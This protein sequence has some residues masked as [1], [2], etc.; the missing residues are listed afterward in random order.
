HG[1]GGHRQVGGPGP[2]RLG[3]RELAAACDHRVRPGPE[4]RADRPRP[5]R[6]RAAVEGG[7]LLSLGTGDRLPRGPKPPPPS[8][9][10]AESPRCPPPAPT[11]LAACPRDA[12]GSGS[13]PDRPPRRD[14]AC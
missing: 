11:R 9:D 13:R 2:A 3:A 8:P 5:P 7:G 6:D 1:E 12:S 4:Q 10:R 14:I